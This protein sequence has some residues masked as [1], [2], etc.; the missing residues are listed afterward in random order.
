MKCELEQQ[1]KVQSDYKSHQQRSERS[2]EIENLKQ[3]FNVYVSEERAK[4]EKKEAERQVIKEAW[5]RQV[6]EKK[7]RETMDKLF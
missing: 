6:E 3:C 1:I 5:Q 4:Q 7:F 2:G